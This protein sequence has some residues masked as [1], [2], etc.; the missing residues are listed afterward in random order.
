MNSVKTKDIAPVMRGDQYRRTHK[1][2]V[3]GIL[4]D[5]APNVVSR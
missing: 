1:A 4:G 5:D 2:S 3:V